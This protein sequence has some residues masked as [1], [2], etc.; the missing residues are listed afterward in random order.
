MPNN[1]HLHAITVDTELIPSALLTA[2]PPKGAGERNVKHACRSSSSKKISV[3]AIEK[4][5]QLCLGD[6][7]LSMPPALYSSAVL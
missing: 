4:K 1:V 6:F 5:H 7:G 2:P 3:V